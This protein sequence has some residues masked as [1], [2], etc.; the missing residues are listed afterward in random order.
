MII[1]PKPTTSKNKPWLYKK[2]QFQDQRM[3]LLQAGE[4]GY[5]KIED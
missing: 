1:E 2:Q 5:H 3:K 4:G